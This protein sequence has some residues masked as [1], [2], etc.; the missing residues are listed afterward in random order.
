MPKIDPNGY[1]AK[2]RNATTCPKCKAVPGEMCR[3]ES[4]YP[5]TG[6]K[7][8][9]HIERHELFLEIEKNRIWDNES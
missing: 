4:P 7:P 3:R 9:N 5:N 8:S 6:S 1:R 2:V